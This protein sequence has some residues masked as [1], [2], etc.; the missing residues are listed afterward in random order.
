MA[1]VDSA[2]KPHLDQSL[3]RAAGHL[4]DGQYM[5][6]LGVVADMA[7]LSC[8][9]GQKGRIFVRGILESAFLNM[10]RPSKAR[11]DLQDDAEKPT[12][13]KLAQ[14][15]DDMLLA[16]RDD[17]DSRTIAYL[18]QI[19]FVTTDLQYETWSANPVILEE[20]L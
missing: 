18:E 1:G 2:T 16:I 7:R 5:A 17:D 10:R 4:K 11:S 6:C 13:S 20:P 3:Q 19:R 9:L 8:L 14:R 12:R 15:I